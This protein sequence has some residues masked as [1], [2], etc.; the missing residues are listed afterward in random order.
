MELTLRS[1]STACPGMSSWDCSACRMSS[2]G[3]SHCSASVQEPLKPSKKLPDTGDV[4]TYVQL[5]CEYQRET[6]HYEYARWQ[7]P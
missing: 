6:R 3:A 4:P 2:A 7:S 5:T 1:T